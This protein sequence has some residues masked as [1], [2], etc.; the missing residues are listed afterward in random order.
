MK[1]LNPNSYKKIEGTK[2]KLYMIIVSFLIFIGTSL[3]FGNV[4]NGTILG[5]NYIGRD[6]ELTNVEYKIEQITHNKSTGKNG[7]KKRLFRRNNPKVYI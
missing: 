4:I 6:K 5:L 7:R 2:L 1:L 3:I